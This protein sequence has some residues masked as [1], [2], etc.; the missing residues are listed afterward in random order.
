MRLIN[1]ILLVLILSLLSAFIYFIQFLLFHNPADTFFYLFQDLAFVPM[2]AIVVTLVL[3]KLLNVIEKRHQLK[4]INVIISAFFAETGM[5]IMYALSELDGNDNFRKLDMTDLSSKGK[6]KAIKNEIKEFKYDIQ[7]TP[8]R[9]ENL[10]DILS[11][12]KSFL[13]KMLENSNLYEH[14]SFTDM[15]WSVFHIADEL[16]NLESMSSVRA[17]DCEHLKT[18]ILRAYPMVLSEWVDYMKYLRDDYPYLFSLALR[19]N[20]L[21][22]D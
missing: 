13:I 15:I 11:Q 8:E 14:D 10:R 3:N 17:E 19:K 6:I 9:L 1:N 18:D 5:S 22:S 20:Q 7:A 4:K 21:S 12:K 2:Q 16:Q